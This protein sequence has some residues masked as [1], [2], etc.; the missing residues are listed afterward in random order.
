MDR[1]IRHPEGPDVHWVTV[2][3]RQTRHSSSTTQFVIISRW[4]T[5]LFALTQALLAPLNR[6]EH[7]AH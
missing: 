6:T 3:E 5:P 1:A 7:L 2:G 4:T